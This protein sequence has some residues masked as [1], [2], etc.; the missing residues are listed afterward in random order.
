MAHGSH[1]IIPIRTLAIVFGLLVMLTIIT[2]VTAQ[3]DLGPFNVPLALAIAGSKALVV[4][5]VFMALKYDNPVNM[6]VMSLGIIFAVVFLAITLTDTALRGTLGIQPS[7]HIPYEVESHEA[8]DHASGD[9]AAV[10]P[11]PESVSDTPPAP[12]AASARSGQVLYAKYCQTCHSTDGSQL[13]GPTFQGIGQKR[14]RE[15][16]TASIMEPD[17]ILV[18]G[19]PGQVMLATLNAFNF[20]EE[21]S[22]AEIEALVDF[23]AA[24]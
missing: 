23:L 16:L 4:A 20:Y 22:D 8:D 11:A 13:A 1:H 2:V 21:V 17:A 24:H 5:A 7:G 3:F 6:I 19:F 12:E 14:T 18:E 15:E 9:T 10:A